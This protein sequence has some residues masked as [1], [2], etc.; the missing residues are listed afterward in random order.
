MSSKY[1]E[2]RTKAKQLDQLLELI[3]LT[4]WNVHMLRLGDS[5]YRI[6]RQEDGAVK[7]EPERTQ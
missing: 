6:V 7:I 5:E 4:H 1:D 2:Y 3:R